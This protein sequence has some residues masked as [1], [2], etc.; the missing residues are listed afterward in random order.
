MARKRKSANDKPQSSPQ[1]RPSQQSVANKSSSRI[2]PT[3]KQSAG[4][5]VPDIGLSSTN[6]Q[7]FSSSG[8]S[9]VSYHAV[10]PPASLN[11]GSTHWRTRQAAKH[12]TINSSSPQFEPPNTIRFQTSHVIDTPILNPI[13]PSVTLPVLSETPGIDTHSL[14]E[15]NNG[16]GSVTPDSVKASDYSLEYIQ[17]LRNFVASKTALE[18]TGYILQPLSEDTIERKK[19]CERCGKSEFARLRVVDSCWQ[20]GL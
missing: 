6:N 15:M 17:R 7:L 20:F 3:P 1:P 10:P 13:E 19:R 18:K 11:S 8:P 5:D 4:Y 14:S 2:P 12:S 16:T 9:Q